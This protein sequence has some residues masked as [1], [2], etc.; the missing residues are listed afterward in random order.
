MNE[1]VHFLLQQM[2]RNREDI[3]GDD[4]IEGIWAGRMI[5]PRFSSS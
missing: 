3:L 1:L 4:G 5:P 2:I